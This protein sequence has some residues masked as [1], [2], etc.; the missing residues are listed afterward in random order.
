MEHQIV[1][2]RREVGNGGNWCML[3]LGYRMASRPASGAEGG[4][5]GEGGFETEIGALEESR[6][7]GEA[8]GEAVG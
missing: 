1:A 8:Q 6:E 3:A 4:R 7:F 5:G 2:S